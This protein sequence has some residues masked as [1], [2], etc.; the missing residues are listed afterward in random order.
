MPRW[1]TRS[2]SRRRVTINHQLGRDTCPFSF[3]RG[4]K[5][6]C[7]CCKRESGSGTALP[8]SRQEPNAP[9][10]PGW[11][12]TAGMAQPESSLNTANRKTGRLG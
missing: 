1:D 7:R 3:D 6:D 9:T 11:A 5:F 4:M 12:S 10:T 8:S 2:N